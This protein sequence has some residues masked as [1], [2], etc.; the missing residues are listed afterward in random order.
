MYNKIYKFPNGATIIYKKRKSNKATAINAGFYCGHQYAN[1]G[2][3]HFFEHMFFKGTTKRSMEQIIDDRSA[4]TFLNAYTN[5]DL[6]CV[7]FYQSNKRLEQSFEFASD[8]LLNSTFDAEKL[9]N[10]VKVVQEEKIRYIDN[11]RKSHMVMHEMYIKKNFKSLETQA[12][13]IFGTDDFLNTIT[14]KDLENYRDEHFV[15][16]KFIISVTT[17]LSFS[18][19]KKLVK[20]YF[21][22]HIKTPETPSTILP[23]EVYEIDRESGV[24]L[25]QNNDK[26]YKAVITIKMDADG[27]NYRYDYNLDCLSDSLGDRKDLYHYEVRRQG[28]AYSCR[29][30]VDYNNFKNTL[31]IGVDFT[32]SSIENISKI[33]SVLGD[34]IQIL[35]KDGLSQEDIDLFKENYIISR[36][37]RRPSSHKDLVYDNLLKYLRYGEEKA[38]TAKQIEKFY[39]KITKESIMENITKCFNKDNDVHITIMGDFTNAQVKTIEEYKQLVFKN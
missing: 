11:S 32:T 39:D 13:R 10:E 35:K 17:N 6:V 30:G 31:W 4:I 38:K 18:K 9:S 5:N 12:D 21:L 29:T 33:L 36:D 7:T 22:N 1:N 26:G 27:H 25:V 15:T 28:L 37:T 16:D 34:S 2:L 24:N 20:K 19:I 23:V 14:P 8:V 3:P